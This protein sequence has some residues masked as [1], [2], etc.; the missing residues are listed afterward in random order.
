MLTKLGI[1]NGV[2]S[3]GLSVP[4]FHHFLKLGFIPFESFDNLSCLVIGI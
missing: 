4:G 2:N 3:E 1:G